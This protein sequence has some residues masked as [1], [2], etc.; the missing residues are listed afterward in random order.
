M[1]EQV[2]RLGIYEAIP[3]IMD[4]VGA[5]PKGSKNQQQG[6]A[7]RGIDDVMKACHTA[8]ST[9][10]VHVRPVVRDGWRCDQVE[11]GRGGTRMFHVIGLV[12]YVFTHQDGSSVTS[13]VFAEATDSADKAA[14][15]AMA[16]AMKYALCQTFCVPTEDMPDAD[17]DSPEL[18]SGN[19]TPEK[20][21][22]RPQEA[23]SPQRQG[24]GTSQEP[25]SPRDKI[26]TL[27]SEMADAGVHG[28][29]P[30]SVLKKLT[31]R[32]YT[33]KDGSQAHFSGWDT[34]DRISEKSMGP[35]YKEVYRAWELWQSSAEKRVEKREAQPE[36]NDDEIPFNW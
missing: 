20:A 4:A 35:T 18:S 15:K 27:C 5:V 6:Y 34:F 2:D 16:A 26:Y 11:I 9:H 21:P 14:N 13:T 32:D 3:A 30:E 12:D 29:T 10:G 24:D 17:A 8:M 36:A 1:T 7:Y 28:D 19:R 22:R 33:K 31:E 23:R 25:G